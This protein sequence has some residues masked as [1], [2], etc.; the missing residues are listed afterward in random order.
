ML[1]LFI[2]TLSSHTSLQFYLVSALLSGYIFFVI[3]FVGLKL[4]EQ[5]DYIVV[6]HF[7]LFFSACKIDININCM[8]AQEKPYVCDFGCVGMVLITYFSVR[9][10]R[11]HRILSHHVKLSFW[12]AQLHTLQKQQQISYAFCVVVVV[13]VDWAK[14]KQNCV[15]VRKTLFFFNYV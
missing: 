13:V 11:T 4:A 14:E 7:I 12:Y 3:I 9:H 8:T 10:V 6:E 2:L 1:Y 15:V 5:Y